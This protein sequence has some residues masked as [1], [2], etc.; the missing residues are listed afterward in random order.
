MILE[1]ERILEK[2]QFE[3]QLHTAKRVGGVRG[4]TCSSVRGYS[5]TDPST[6]RSDK[7]QYFSKCAPPPPPEQKDRNRVKMLPSHVEHGNNK[8]KMEL[9]Y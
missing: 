9:E 2:R 3:Y 1:T 8:A 4:L 6:C 7:G 5:S